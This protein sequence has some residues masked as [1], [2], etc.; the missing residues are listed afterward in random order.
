M[1]ERTQIPTDMLAVDPVQSRDDPWTGD[2][3]D[4]ELA[5]AVEDVGLLQDIIV[6]PA[7]HVSSDLSNQSGNDPEYLI[8]AGSRRYYAAVQAGHETVPCK[9][10]EKD[11][12]EAAWISLLE[13][14]ERRDLS[15][16]EIANQLHLIYE[17]VRPL[18]EPDVC[19]QCG[20]AVDGETGLISHYGHSNC[21]SQPIEQADIR[22]DESVNGRFT[23]DRQA[24]RYLADRYL[25]R[26]D[27]S[28]LSIIE[29]HLRT[30]QLPPVLQSLF[31]T[32]EERSEQERM[33]LENHGIDT[34]TVLGSGEG[35]SK[36]S[37]V[38]V[39]VHNTLTDEFDEIDPTDA[40]LKTV[41]RLRTKDTSEKE[42]ERTMRQFRRDLLAKAEAENTR[43]QTIFEDVLQAHVTELREAREELAPSQPFRRVDVRAPDKERYN[44]W[45][46]QEH[47]R[48]DVR[49]HG[50]LIQQ[51][52]EER[53]ETL[54]D[55]RG[56]E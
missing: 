36:A 44:R 29:G 1:I 41:G 34:T 39:S 38:I 43:Q 56:W 14:T 42:F 37:E 45:Y 20:T 5:A 26:V 6:R 40:V 33:A 17:L 32:P 24:R 50:Q 48:R 25:G 9:I 16:R 53:L 21:D 46:A 12:Q 15:E 27:E 11:D 55:Q 19:P 4:Q 35:H 7:D 22:L 30:A 10:L 31:K 51:L 28:A 2:Q 47:T 3:Q 18:H 13:N 23:T 54:A 49:S 8:V 52:Y